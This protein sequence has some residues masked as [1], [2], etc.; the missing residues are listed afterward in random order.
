MPF[1]KAI[2]LR[3]SLGFLPALMAWPALAQNNGASELVAI[4]MMRWEERIFK[5]S[6]RYRSVILDDERVLRAEARASASALYQEIEI[7]LTKTPY[8]SWRWLI[9]ETLDGVLNEQTKAGDDYVARIYV[10]QSGG[11]A[12]WRSKALNYVWTS[13][14]EQGARWNNAFGQ[15]N[16]KMW[17]LNSGSEGAG[18]WQSHTRDVRVDWLK[19]FGEEIDHIDGVAIMTDTDNTGQFATAWYADIVFSSAPAN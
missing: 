13:G 15:G 12:F 6:T 17:S 1:I 3:L 8:L 19:A 2:T 7:D 18:D 11:L 16:V 9:E 10:I 4:D 5:G 14:Q